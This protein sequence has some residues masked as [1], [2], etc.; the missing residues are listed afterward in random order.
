[1][2]IG[3]NTSTIRPKKKRGEKACKRRWRV[4]RAMEEIPAE[5]L[6]VEGPLARRKG[7]KH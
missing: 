6:L 2:S 3:G 1:V 4:E 5:A 7:G